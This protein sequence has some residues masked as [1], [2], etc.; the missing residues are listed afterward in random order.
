M[1]TSKEV[2]KRN[3]PKYAPGNISDAVV[4]MRSMLLQRV[5][6]QKANIGEGDGIIRSSSAAATGCEVTASQW[7]TTRSTCQ[8]GTSNAH[9]PNAECPVCLPCCL[10]KLHRV[11]KKLC[12][13]IFCQNFAKFRRIIKIF[14]TKI[15]ER[16]SFSEVYSFSTSPIL[17]QHTTV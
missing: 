11:S 3:S 8:P 7:T 17:C 9:P 2:P 4:A 1:F 12:K 16:T 14:G 10:A 15:A 6:E 5:M 13:L